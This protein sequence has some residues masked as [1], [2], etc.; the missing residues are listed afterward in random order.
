MNQPITPQNTDK[1]FAL[2]TWSIENKMTVYVMMAIIIVGGLIAFSSMPRESFPEVI[3]NK[4][5]ISSVYPGNSSADVEKFIT[6]KIEKEI[7]SVSGI[8][9]VT[10]TSYNDYAMTIVE[11]G[12]DTQLA[13][14]KQDIKDKIDQVKAT[15]DWPTMDTGAKVEPNVFDLNIAEV[16]PIS[17]INITGN[18][19]TTQLNDYA[20]MLQDDIEAMQSIKEAP[21]RGINDRE[22]V[23]ALDVYKMGASQVS[24]NDVANSIS[25]DNKTIS[26]GN[27]I[28]ED[29]RLNIRVVGEI[30]NPQ[31]LYSIV[32]K[33]KDGVVF[34]RDIAEISFQEKDKTT[35]ARETGEPV[36]MMDILKRSGENMID[37][38]ENIEKIIDEAM[39]TYLPNDL[40]VK[41][42][43]N[44]APQTQNQVDDLINNIVFGVILVIGVLMFFLGFRNASFVGLAIPLSMLMALFILSLLGTTL[45]TMVLFGLVMG[46]GMLVDNGIVV[47][48]NVYSLMNQGYSRKEAAKQGIGEIAWPIIA[49][50]ATTLAAFTPLALW[51]GVMGSFLKIFP[52][53]ISVVLGSSLFVA[54]VIN[55]MIT[56]EFM[57]T[58]EEDKKAVDKKKLLI[59]SLIIGITGVILVIL[60][61]SFDIEALRI[62]GNLFALTA[63][64]L[65]VYELW[66]YP[67]SIWLQD[68][69]LPWLENKYQNFLSWG[70]KDHNPRWIVFGTF[71][72]FVI[73]IILFALVQPKV[74][75]FPEN[76]PN[77][78]IV[79]IEYPEGTDIEKTNETTRRIEHEVIN[80]MQQYVV[81]E[82]GQ[83]HNFMAEA[84][85][86]QVGEGAGNP[87]VDAGSAAEIPHKGKITVSLREYRYRRGIRS[88]DVLEEVRKAVQ[89]FAGVSVIVE[90]NQ[91]GPP[92]GYPISIEVTG[93][94]YH[95]MMDEVE[96]LQQFIEESGVD[97]IEELKV[98]VSR[99]IPQLTV[100]VNRTLAGSLGIT[101]QMVGGTLR[102]SVFGQE[103]SRYRPEGD[104]DDYPVTIRLRPEQRY[105]QSVIFNQPITFMDASTGRISQIPISSIVSQSRERQF[106]QIKRRDFKRVI[107]LYSNVLGNYNPTETVN[108]IKEKLEQSSY[109]MPDGISYRFA[110]EQEKQA[111]NMSF[112]VNALLI[113]VA[114]ISLI[115]IA[116]FNSISKPVI[117]ML[118][119]VLSFI[120][121]FL[122]LIV[123]R[124]DFVVMMTMMGI[125]SLAGIVVNNSIVLVDYTQLLLNRRKKELGLTENYMLPPEEMTPLVVEGGRS[126]LRPVLLTAITTVLGLVPLA[127]GLNI[128]FHGL[129]SR[130]D[131]NIYV[132]GDN[133]LFWG[134][135]AKTVIYGL[136][137][138]TFLTLIVVPI[139]QYMVNKIK[140]R[141]K[142][143]KNGKKHP[144]TNTYNQNN[145]YVPESTENT[146]EPGII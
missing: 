135:L 30:T 56:G 125:I 13:I 48:E 57:H 118:T 45:N 15:A 129:F 121:V 28:N 24:F 41:I 55:A 69:G 106:S 105:D 119:V 71:G 4:V 100:E 136:V 12:G 123:M 138:A 36:I 22:V 130:Y 16:V 39:Q 3:E 96:K 98:D 29:Q 124:D 91:V 9:D 103:V 140:F 127:I 72:L 146:P 107:T 141:V 14:A 32:V 82:D 75:F 8:I 49:S 90:K 38:N 43:N 50:T 35:Y 126:R 93:D 131:P 74:L 65:W 20:R 85:L 17:N 79:Y 120:G 78:I 94:D 77:Q 112:L 42:T 117:I 63:I 26:G 81:N 133:V 134:P 115:I 142:Y 33:Q 99:D 60:G 67:A 27:L 113:A 116:Q 7:Q 18:Y 132:G 102:Q 84:I 64:M 108:N 122:G 66:L 46:L 73:S 109:S 2:S 19:T 11:F 51:P 61:F 139:M 21:I 5:Y 111:E 97:G 47:V 101:N 54:L 52:I 1:N 137:F 37:A 83:S 59:R 70:L 58:E 68:K 89:G 88:S 95:A 31:D 143:G 62:F 86:T 34:L 114:L 23:V 10:S 110:G 128:D 25:G 53:T 92:A 87:M 145:E 44:Q 6:E 104:E 40:E 76:D 80:V 144:L